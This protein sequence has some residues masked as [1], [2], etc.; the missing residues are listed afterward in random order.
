M[1]DARPRPLIRAMG[2]FGTDRISQDIAN[3]GQEVFILL[4][5]KALISALPDVATGFGKCGGSGA[6]GW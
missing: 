2:Q 6:H 1:L 3:D 5:R 4:N